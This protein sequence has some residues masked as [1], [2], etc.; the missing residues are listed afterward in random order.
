MSSNHPRLQ[1]R[2]Y[3]ELPRQSRE[4]KWP[5]SQTANVK[6]YLGYLM[7]FENNSLLNKYRIIIK[8]D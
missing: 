3:K 4:D 2:K 1:Q 6:L 8:S 5:L 7:L